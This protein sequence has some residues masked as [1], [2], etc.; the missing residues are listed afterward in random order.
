MSRNGLG[1]LATALLAILCGWAVASTG[2]D[3]GSLVLPVTL[4]LLVLGLGVA[5]RKT[6]ASLRPF[7]DHSVGPGAQELPNPTRHQLARWLFFAGL[8]TMP[9]LILRFRG[10]TV[11][12]YVFFAAL[13]VAAVSV[14]GDRTHPLPKIPGPLLIGLTLLLTGSLIATVE[15]SLDPAG[16][17]AIIVRLTYLMTGWLLLG[18]VI[19][20]TP[21]HVRNAVRWWVAGVAVCGLY[22]TAQKAGIAPGGLD[23]A[24]RATGLAEHVN[25]LGALSAVAGVPAL[26]LAYTM[27]DL[28]SWGSAIGVLLGLMLSG[29]IGAAVAMLAG[30]LV[31]A[32]S[33]QLTRAVLVLSL[34]GGCAVAL[35]STTSVLESTPIGRFE[36]A[37]DPAGGTLRLR[38]DTAAD[39]WEGIRDNPV[40][41]TGLDLRSSQIYSAITGEKYSVHNLFLARWYESGVAGLLGIGLIVW[42]LLTAGWTATRR[43]SGHDRLLAISLLAGA[44][45]FVAVGMSEPLLYKRYAL[46][47]AAL[48]LA[49]AAQQYRRA[50]ASSLVSPGHAG[51]ATRA[52]T[53]S[54]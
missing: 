51:H 14:L 31:C 23:Q 13:V 18:T 16:S 37:T 36:L 44:V 5:G 40:I 49:L 29:S 6:L 25:D 48:A 17:V 54:P 1:L 15:R 34:V 30:L 27:R 2:A 10:T 24:G 4:T 3:I 46:A 26:M 41:G 7:G 22:A 47:P 53:S 42:A 19:L 52:Q 43:S 50:P 33:G 38:V 35:A 12:D 39:A 20:R 45:A 11:S 32:I 8:A 9:L 21:E 28:I